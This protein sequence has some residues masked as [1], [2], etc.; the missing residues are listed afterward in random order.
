[1]M[2]ITVSSSAISLCF[3]STKLSH[4]I[5]NL[6]KVESLLLNPSRLCLYFIF[7]GR[8]TQLQ[9]SF[10]FANV[11]TDEVKRERDVLTAENKQVN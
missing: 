10:E 5:T 8:L 11:A 9:A 1:M 7:E 2:Y 3:E 6:S 4:S